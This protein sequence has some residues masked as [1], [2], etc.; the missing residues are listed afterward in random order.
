MILE[1]NRLIQKHPKTRFIL[2]HFGWHANDLA[3]AEI[4]R[5]RA[6]SV[7]G[8]GCSPYDFAGNR[9]ARE[10]FREV[11]GPHSLRQGLLGA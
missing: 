1:R 11:S 9:A 5:Q 10:F 8:C 6:Q 2:A 7:P 3:R 4:T